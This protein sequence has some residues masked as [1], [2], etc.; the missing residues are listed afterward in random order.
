MVDAV[1]QRCFKIHP[2][3]YEQTRLSLDAQREMPPGETTYEPLATAPRMPDG[4][5]LLAVRA[6]HCDLPDIAAALAAM[7]AN[8]WG[9]EISEDEYQAAI[10]MPSVNGP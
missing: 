9:V 6:E 3:P 10:P 1:S 7:F 4:D 2:E 8:G 5:V